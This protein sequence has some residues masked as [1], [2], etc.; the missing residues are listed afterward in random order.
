MIIKFIILLYTSYLWY[1][2]TKPIFNLPIIT[3]INP[4][5]KN[6]IKL[7]LSYELTNTNFE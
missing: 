2:L 1:V 3:F 6:V 4:L 7:T 5:Q